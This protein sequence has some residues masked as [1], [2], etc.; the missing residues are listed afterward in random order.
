[1]PVRREGRFVVTSPEELNKWL[2]K[3]VGG[4]PLHVATPDV[5]LSAEL[6]RGLAF[7]TG[8]KRRSRG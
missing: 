1:M 3:E 5:D 4:E 2:G 7:V 6:K 8:R